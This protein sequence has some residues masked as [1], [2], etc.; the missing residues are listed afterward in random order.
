M[1]IHRPG[2]PPTDVLVDFFVAAGG[3]DGAERASEL[4]PIDVDFGDTTQVFHVG[5][6]SCGVPGIPAGLEHVN[7]SATAPMPLADLI[8]PGVRLARDGVELTEQQAYLFEIL[9]PI[10]TGSPEGAALY[11]PGGADPPRERVISLARS[12]RCPGAV[13]EPRAQRPSTPAR[14]EPGSRTWSARE[15]G[16]S[17]AGTCR[18]TSR[19]SASRSPPA[20]AAPMS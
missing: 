17:A 3:A 8:G 15:A 16:P 2:S 11:A 20:S 13:R 10:L 18:R 4:V 12:G 19:S 5:A 7:G 14:S 6:A 1:L 9:E